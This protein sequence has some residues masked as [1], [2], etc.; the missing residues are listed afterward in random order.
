MSYFI[1][2]KQFLLPYEMK[3]NIVMHRDKQKNKSRLFQQNYTHIYWDKLVEIIHPY[4]GFIPDPYRNEGLGVSDFGFISGKN[5]TPI[6][7]KSKDKI[8]IAF[9][10]GSFSLGTYFST[11]ES[12]KEMNRKNKEIVLLNFSAGGYK[13]PQ[14]LLILAYLLSLG[15]D[16]DVV[17]NLDGYNELVLPETENI[18]AHVYPFYPRMW[19]SR[20]MG[21]LD[22]QTIK[23]LAFV[24]LLKD[25][26]SDWTE[27]FY[28]N[29]LFYSPLLYTIWQYRENHLTEKINRSTEEI[30][31][32]HYSYRL[33]P[34]SI[35]TLRKK[36]LPSHI[37][38]DLIPL[39][40]RSFSNLKELIAAIE[41]Q[42]GP[43]ETARYK[44]PILSVIQTVDPTIEYVSKGPDY[45]FSSD[46]EFIADLAN[47]WEKSSLQ[48]K[49][50]CDANDIRYY[51][52]LQ[53]CL[54]LT[55][56]KLMH[57]NEKDLMHS[58]DASFQSVIEKGYPCLKKSGENLKQKGIDFI[59]LTM[60][61]NENK[62]TLYTDGCHLN[63]QGYTIV[64]RK[65]REYIFS[66]QEQPAD[67]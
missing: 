50:L 24:E 4:F 41:K 42:I 8:I 20:T 29:N 35:Q 16:F 23:K 64:S 11:K 52:F 9:F 21:L 39:Q 63:D 26:A 53:P 2:H 28:Q 7:K 62:E 48:M 22:H 25:H 13:Q 58:K 66:D 56:S 6:H 67:G 17:I 44:N 3:K 36:S 49:N 55:G 18:R 5:S 38:D 34:Y 43:T 12:L 32:G 65:I 27:F 33:S 60:I 19:H 54:Y 40:N 1:I 45:S 37:T 46:D 51:H 57:Q 10:G 61:F 14:Q 15:A 59:D 47:V 30:V 31:F